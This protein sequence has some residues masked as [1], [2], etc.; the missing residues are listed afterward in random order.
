MFWMLWQIRE[1]F[2]LEICALLLILLTVES[3]SICLSTILACGCGSVFAQCCFL[4]ALK[5]LSSAK[6]YYQNKEEHQVK[7]SCSIAC[8]TFKVLCTMRKWLGKTTCK[9]INI[10]VS[11]CLKPTIT[12]AV[13]NQII[14][15]FIRASPN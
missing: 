6:S 8:L 11:I 5:M 3:G 14:Y 1:M 2:N 7:I 13:K 4:M 9:I 15:I 12:F 10:S